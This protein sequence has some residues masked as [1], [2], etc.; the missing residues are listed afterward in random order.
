[1][2]VSIMASARAASVEC[3]LPRR[4]P[5]PAAGLSLLHDE[6]RTAVN[7]DKLYLVLM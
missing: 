2:L 1:M 3:V 4:K 6:P 7:V 5:G